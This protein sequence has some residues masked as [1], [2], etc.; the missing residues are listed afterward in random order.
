MKSKFSEAD[1]EL[2][3][4]LRAQGFT[5]DSI[6]EKTGVSRGT[7]CDWFRAEGMVRTKDACLPSIDV[8]DISGKVRSPKH[9]APKK[10]TPGTGFAF[11]VAEIEDERKDEIRNAARSGDLRHLALMLG[12]DPNEWRFAGEIICPDFLDSKQCGR[13]CFDLASGVH[14]AVA[15]DHAFI[16]SADFEIWIARAQ[17]RVEPF[18][19]FIRFCIAAQGSG[20][21]ELSRRIA[22]LT[23]GWQPLAWALERLRPECYHVKGDREQTIDTDAFSEIGDDNIKR[24][25]LAFIKADNDRSA[26]DVEFIDLDEIEG[27]N[28]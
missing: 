14:R 19:S 26:S 16:D 23:P 9:G 18:Y 28:E 2:A 11:E 21:V 3:K 27:R 24:T 4:S 10:P 1:R 13:L 5:Y 15:I 7:L 8:P 6:A 22:R 20:C 17:N 25:A 12:S